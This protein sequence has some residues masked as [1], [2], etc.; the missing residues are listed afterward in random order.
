MKINRQVFEENVCF[1][2]NKNF[3]LDF[4]I[5]FANLSEEWFQCNLLSEKSIHIVWQSLLQ[6]INVR[7]MKLNRCLVCNQY[8]HI[9][10]NESNQILINKDLLLCNDKPV[11]ECYLDPNYS[12]ILQIIL[13]S[14]LNNS[15]TTRSTAFQGRLKIDLIEIK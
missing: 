6:S 12:K 4:S 15:S 5:P 2:L 9:T 8:T 11:E 7:D 13:P 3:C 1:F 14:G 10:N